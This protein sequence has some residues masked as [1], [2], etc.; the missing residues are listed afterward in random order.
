MQVCKCLVFC[1]AMASAASGADPLNVLWI[2]A[3]DHAA[4]VT[5][6]YGNEQ[7][8]TPNIDRLAAAGMRFDRAYC[9]APVCTAS[10]GSFMTG[11]YPRTI[12]VTL[13]RT[14]LPEHELTMADL[15]SAAGYD[16]IAIGKTHF[17]SQL[18]HGFDQIVSAQ[19]HR[20]ALRQRGGPRE[21]PSSIDVLPA[22]RPFRQ[23]A[24]LWVNAVHLPYGTYDHDMTGT[25]FAE[26]AAEF[27]LEQRERPF[28][29]FVSFHEPHSP[30]HYPVEYR[31]RHR[32]SDFNVPPIG[33]DDQQQIPAVFRDLS[34]DDIRGIRASYY[35]SVEFLDKNVGI[36]LDALQ[37][38]GKSDSTLVVY[39]GDHG[40]M[41]G[42]HG[43][44]EKHCCYE[45]AILAPLI[46]CLPGKVTPASSSQALVEFIDVFPTIADLCRVAAPANVQGRSLVPVLLGKSDHHRDRVFVEY[47]QNEEAMVRDHRWKLI[48]QRGTVRRTDGYDTKLPLKGPTLRLYDMLEDPG[49]FHNV[50][51]RPE[52]ADVANALVEQLRQ[53]LVGTSRLPEQIP[54]DATTMQVLEHCVQPRDGVVP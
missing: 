12:G 42:Q 36:V 29:A 53:L 7:V 45:P 13:L 47:A 15:L 21:V 18:K 6:C 51:D 22:W 2:C 31:D 35:T 38:S 10:R 48:Y 1:L 39:L 20:R 25:Y 24:R 5:G 27:V 54:Q 8:R 43:R 49:E 14:P 41:L 32:P 9:N 30:F 33:P 11:R 23:P 52:N 19:D 34:P 28:F 4:Y 3:D 46:F 40:Y 50:A 16:T 26:R 44:I 37:R 17:N